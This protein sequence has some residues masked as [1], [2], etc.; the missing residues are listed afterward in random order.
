M[1]TY[2]T[3][4]EVKL[5][6]HATGTHMSNPNIV[7]GRA[8]DA[9]LTDAGRAEAIMKGVELRSRGITP[10]IIMSSPAVRCR[11]TG[12]L[13]LGA[14]RLDLPILIDPLL[15]EMDMGEFVG[16]DRT[17]AY[18]EAT[19]AQIKQFGKDFKAPGGESRNEVGARGLRWLDN[20]RLAPASTRLAIAFTHGGLI[21]STVA[22]IEGW[23]ADKAFAMQR[24][25]APV[26]E[27]IL[28]RE[29]GTW[30]VDTFAR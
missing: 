14:M 13:V 3:E 30:H 6:R 10:N 7:I 21:S 12:R 9:E 19:L 26:S 17:I 25:I 28:I 18:D 8:L 22:S 20:S 15:H 1:V 4:L 11:E 29:D 5:I 24:T 27:T 23:D 16:V 2:M